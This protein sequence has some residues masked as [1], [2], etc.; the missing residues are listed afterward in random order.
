MRRRQKRDEKYIK[1]YTLVG[2]EEGKGLFGR[3]R[4][5]HESDSVIF[6]T[7]QGVKI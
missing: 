2:K 6:Y 5:R 3:S 1:L 7:K 4:C